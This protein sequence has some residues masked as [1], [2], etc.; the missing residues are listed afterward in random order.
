MNGDLYLEILTK[1]FKYF[2]RMVVL[3]REQECL[4]SLALT[5]VLAHKQCLKYIQYHKLLSRIFESHQQL[6]EEPESLEMAV[7]F[8][9]RVFHQK[10]PQVARHPRPRNRQDLT[11]AGTCEFDEST[12]VEEEDY[13]DPSSKKIITN[14]LLE[15]RL[16]LEKEDRKRR[17]DIEKKKKYDIMSDDQ[18]RAQGR[19]KL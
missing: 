3:R 12:F 17:K 11:I 9:G 13:V 10:N 6:K 18:K 8:N 1:D 4:F 2:Y 5:K 7:H 14:I 19:L 15:E 16:L